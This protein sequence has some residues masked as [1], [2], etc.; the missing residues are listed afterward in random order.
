[1][2]GKLE[3][4]PEPDSSPIFK[5]LTGDSG[6]KK[7]VE[8]RLTKQEQFHSV[9]IMW[10]VDNPE[11]RVPN[12]VFITGSFWGWKE[13]KAMKRSERGFILTVDLFGES[14]NQEAKLLNGAEN[15]T[16]N[17]CGVQPYKFKFIVDGVWRCS[18]RYQKLTEDG[19]ENNIIFV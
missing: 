7:E 1:M 8:Q 2:N 14:I 12:E 18:D 16:T 5:P 13:K 9:E 6:S 15:G 19:N 17:G 4:A 10:D 11:A 3:L